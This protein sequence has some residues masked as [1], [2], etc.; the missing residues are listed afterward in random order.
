MFILYTASYV[1]V[2]LGVCDS[3]KGHQLGTSV[4]FTPGNWA[5]ISHRAYARLFKVAKTMQTELSI[6]P[7]GTLVVHAPARFSY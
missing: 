3:R 6:D 1:L 7:R 5:Y 4:G 2:W